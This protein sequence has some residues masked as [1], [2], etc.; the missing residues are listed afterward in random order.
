MAVGANAHLFGC[1]ALT[2]EIDEVDALFCEERGNLA[3]RVVRTERGDERHRHAVG[4][5]QRSGERGAA[6]ARACDRLV[7]DGNRRVG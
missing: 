1:A 4:R 5:E 2:L 3:S 6:R 7:D